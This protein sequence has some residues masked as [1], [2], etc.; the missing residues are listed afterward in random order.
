VNSPVNTKKN[1]YPSLN[2]QKTEKEG[3]LPQTFYEA[4]LIPKPEKDTTPKKKL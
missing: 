1:L 2:F 3:I 4:T